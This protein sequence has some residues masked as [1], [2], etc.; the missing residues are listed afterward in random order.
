MFKSIFRIAYTTALIVVLTSCEDHLVQPKSPAF[1]KKSNGDRD[2]PGGF[3]QNPGETYAYPE[4]I[5]QEFIPSNEYFA[6]FKCRTW[7]ITWPWIDGDYNSDLVP[8]VLS[9][10]SGQLNSIEFLNNNSP[11]LTYNSTMSLYYQRRVESASTMWWQLDHS[12]DDAGSED[13]ESVRFA[14]IDMSLTSIM[15]MVQN[16]PKLFMSNWPGS[17]SNDLEY[18]EGDFILFHL[19]KAD[20]YGGIRIVSMTP[21]IIEVYLAIPHGGK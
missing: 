7:R 14:K 1:G 10:N 5:E 19:D 20:L 12:F 9:V 2:M 8:T 3:Q 11:S 18:N 4:I 13:M 21:R 15:N 6:Y 16:R 17:T